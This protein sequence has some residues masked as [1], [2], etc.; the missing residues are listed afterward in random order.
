M[1][2]SATVAQRNANP[3][4]Y[5]A[6][7]GQLYR[8][9][10]EWRLFVESSYDQAR[11]IAERSGKPVFC[12]QTKRLDL[13]T[14]KNRWVK[15]WQDIEGWFDEGP[16]FGPGVYRRIVAELPDSGAGIVEI[17]SWVGKSTACMLT[18]LKEAGKSAAFHAI[19]TWEG[20]PSDPSGRL[21]KGRNL[22]LEWAS[23]LRDCGF[24]A[25]VT[26]HKMPSVAAAATFSDASLDFVYIDADH[27][28]EAV[29]EDIRAWW[30][31]VK[32]GGVMAGHDYDH[33]TDPGVPQAVDEFAHANGLVAEVV[34]VRNWW[35][36]K[37][38][39]QSR[40]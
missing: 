1:D 8:Q 39:A 13:P 38:E 25:G 32:P 27:A 31:K 18:L 17:G 16:Y 4:A 12:T 24:A 40:Q 34:D 5:G 23:N 29:S 9:R 19:D 22:L 20:S 37:P 35:I 6:G 3:L 21:A 15:T 26:A 2:Q 28:Y 10:P 33:R 14:W 30:S 7:K 36:R 11:E